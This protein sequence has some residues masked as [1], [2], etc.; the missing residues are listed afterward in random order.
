MK[1]TKH[2]EKLKHKRGV[3]AAMVFDL[4]CATDPEHRVTKAYVALNNAI[5]QL[6]ALDP[7]ERSVFEQLAQ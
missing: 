7:G 4:N 3:L 5:D 6:E 1:F 2:I